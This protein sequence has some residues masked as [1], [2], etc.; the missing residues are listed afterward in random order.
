MM[1]NL[2]KGLGTYSFDRH[3]RALP[4]DFIA[5]RLLA[6]WLEI[7]WPAL[8][9]MT[10]GEKYAAL[11]RT[12]SGFWFVGAH[13]DCDRLI[14]GIAGDLDLPAAARRRNTG[15]DWENR[16]SWRRLRVEEL[17]PKTRTAILAN[18]PLDHALWESWGAAGFDP[19]GI[20]PRPLR[21]TGNRRFVAHEL[22]RPIFAGVC[23]YQRDWAFRPH[24]GGF[25]SAV[26]R[27]ILRAERAQEERKWDLAAR[28]YRNVLTVTPNMPEMWVQ[29]GQALKE[30]GRAI[31]AEVAFRRSLSLDPN[32]ADAHLQLGHLLKIQGRSEEAAHAFLRSVALDRGPRHARD[33]LIGL[34]WTAE[35]IEHGLGHGAPAAGDGG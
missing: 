18:N 28:C 15:A 29:Y 22:V 9:T 24:L 19:A 13:A 25:G 1:I 20:R 21:S 32:S 33:Q 11:N 34:G 17:A 2:T 7:P 12:L 14:A 8:M 26:G 10:D 23:R 27:R 35:Q 16:A 5:H 31:E 6:R 3:I 4:R 30:V